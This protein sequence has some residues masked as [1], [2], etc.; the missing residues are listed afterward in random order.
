MRH[1]V[2]FRTF[3]LAQTVDAP[4]QRVEFLRRF[5]HHGVGGW[6]VDGWTAAVAERAKHSWWRQDEHHRSALYGFHEA[7]TGYVERELLWLW[8]TFAVYY[9]NEPRRFRMFLDRVQNHPT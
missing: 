7:L 5:L 3:V 6:T 9:D 8:R 4:G 2:A 1:S